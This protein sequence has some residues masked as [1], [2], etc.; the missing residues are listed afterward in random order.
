METRYFKNNEEIRSILE[1]EKQ[2]AIE[3][4]RAIIACGDEE[5]LERCMGRFQAGAKSYGINPPISVQKE[6]EGFIRYTF[7][8][9]QNKPG[10][11]GYVLSDNQYGNIHI[12]YLYNSR[13]CI[14]FTL[15][16]N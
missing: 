2:D 6:A 12:P 15:E 11:M 4:I 13:K 1:S 10:F 14:Q 16:N 7:K 3:E 8:A 5:E 9:L